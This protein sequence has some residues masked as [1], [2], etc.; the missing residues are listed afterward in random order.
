MAAF[1]LLWDYFRLLLYNILDIVVQAIKLRCYML[2][3]K[4][5]MVLNIL[6]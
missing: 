2:E 1:N 4:G 3:D 6:N 5:D